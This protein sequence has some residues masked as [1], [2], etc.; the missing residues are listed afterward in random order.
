[1]YAVDFVCKLMVSRFEFFADPVFVDGGCAG[2]EKLSCRR[3]VPMIH[4]L[5]E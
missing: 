4:H 2:V 3:P 1:M 5:L